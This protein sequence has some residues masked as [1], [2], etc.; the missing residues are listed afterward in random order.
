MAI[1]RRKNRLFVW[2][3]LMTFGASFLGLW[4]GHY[5]LLHIHQDHH[6]FHF[7]SQSHNVQ[8][9]TSWK[10]VLQEMNNRTIQAR[11]ACNET[12]TTRAFGWNIDAAINNI[13]QHCNYPPP[14]EC[15]AT[16]YSILILWS[17][18]D[19]NTTLRTLFVNF[20]QALTLPNVMDIQLWLFDFEDSMTTLQNDMKYGHRILSWH[21]NANHK[22]V[23]VDA[24]HANGTTL[25]QSRGAVLLL[26]G[27]ISL[28]LHRRNIQLAHTVWKRNADS[29]VA[30]DIVRLRTTRSFSSNTSLLSTLCKN[31]SLALATNDKHA[32]GFLIP[33]FSGMWIHVDFLCALQE[34]N[35]H[36]SLQAFPWT[37]GVWMMQV[38]APRPMHL[39]SPTLRS[40]E[41]NP[42]RIQNDNEL[43]NRGVK[44]NFGGVLPT[45]PSLVDWCAA[46]DATGNK[47]IPCS[48]AMLAIDTNTFQYD[49]CQ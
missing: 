19:E 37:I 47:P 36:H 5:A 20:L 32:R 3:L 28:S 15:D 16:D 2:L 11:R 24:N 34:W 13:T 10:R 42:H 41:G 7:I 29:I 23:L 46:D 8:S 30:S 44:S 6:L 27:T 17:A 33:H 38:T 43:L 39:Y 18:S 31:E 45:T 26:D 48:K 35:H 1:A 22:L 12:T 9:R 49:K 40:Q 14:L 4:L 25:P 21:D